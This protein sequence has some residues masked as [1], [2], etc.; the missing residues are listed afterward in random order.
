MWHLALNII[1]VERY[2]WGFACDGCVE[3]GDLKLT[4]SDALPNIFDNE[5]VSDLDRI[6]NVLRD[7][8][9]R[10]KSKGSDVMKAQVILRGGVLEYE[11]WS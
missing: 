4:P 2:C 10:S 8:D 9:A 6:D 11:D 7:V 5:L 1:E 3:A